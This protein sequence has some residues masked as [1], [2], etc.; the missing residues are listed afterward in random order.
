MDDP[1]TT[2]TAQKPSGPPAASVPVPEPASIP[3]A[4]TSPE[5]RKAGGRIISIVAMVGAVLLILWVWAA[6]ERHPRTDDAIVQANIIG[7]TPRAHG[8][9]IQLNVA[10]NQEV[11]SNDVLFQIDPADYKLA[12]DNAEAALGALDQ[13]I[14][15]A[16]AHDDELKFQVKAAEAGVIQSKAQL[17]Q[18]TDTLQRIQPLLDKGFV[19]AD[20]VEKAQTEVDVATATL[21]AQ[22]Q[23]SNQAK[24]TLSTLTTLQ[25]QRPGAVAAVEQAKL[26]LSYCTVTAPFPG[27]VVNLNISA[28]GY[29]TI[30]VP[31]FALVDT[32][33]WYVIANFREGEIR[34]FGPGSA[35]D[36]YLLSAPRRHFT[37]KVQGIGW[38][39]ESKDEIDLSHGVPSVPRELNWVH[40]AQRFPVRIAVENPDPALFRVGASA[41]AII[42]SAPAAE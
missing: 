8:Q 12:V 32:R 30:G 34:H 6:V 21:A 15:V 17:K 22:E 19:T 26:N 16:R 31:V 5:W 36:L 24:S 33:Q 42:K 2:P 4:H 11:N 3:V 1:A 7:V 38:A 41:V 18:A 23:H 14:A 13:Q 28:G 37:G 27:R 9:I 40:I 39:V 10:D 20:Q 35:V 29:A 25:A